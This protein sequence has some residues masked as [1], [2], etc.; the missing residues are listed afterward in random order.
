MK[1][2][3]SILTR[4]ANGETLTSACAALGI[5]R[6]TFSKHLRARPDL[7][8]RL[9]A[10]K[11]KTGVDLV[12]ERFSGILAAIEAGATMQSAVEAAGCS[13][14]SFLKYVRQHDS[15]RYVRASAT[16]EA[17]GAARGK[18]AT[19]RPQP[20]LHSDDFEAAL[21]ALAD[22][23]RKY[24][25]IFSDP[26]MPSSRSVAAFARKNAAFRERLA[27]VFA[28]RRQARADSRPKPAP[29]VDRP[30]GQLLRA[31]KRNDLYAAALKVVGGFDP[32]D[33]DDGISE[34]IL[35]VLGG[36]LSEADIPKIGKRYASRRVL[37]AP[38]KLASLDAPVFGSEDVEKIVDTFANNDGVLFY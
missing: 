1:H 28:S 11:P 22:A 19:A 5:K 15:G 2:F 16:R 12:A 36:E 24:E 10:A 3:N 14:P 25:D 31:L 32:S 37:A 9:D 17:G 20:R 26:L 30:L 34:I 13:V 38:R 18:R 27:N 6:C 35:A 23:S 33:R 7:R 21:D 4:V 8:A 29:K